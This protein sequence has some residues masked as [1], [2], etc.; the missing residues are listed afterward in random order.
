MQHKNMVVQKRDG[1]F[2][3]YEV[4]K[5]KDCVVRACVGLEVDCIMLESLFD[6]CIFDGIK[7]VDIQKNLIHHAKT[8]C[9]PNSPDWTVVAGR[10]ET[11]NL[12]A[13]TGAYELEFKDFVKKQVSEGIWKHPAFA[14]YTEDDIV[15]IGS[16]LDR[17]RDLNHSY[18][19]VITARNKYLLPGECIQHMF[20]GNAMIIASVENSE[21]R[22]QMIKQTYDDLSNRIISSATPWLGNLRSNGNISSCFIIAPSD[23]IDSI[24]NNLHHAASISKNGGGLGIFIGFLRAR[25]SDLMGRSGRSGGIIGWTKLFNDVALFVNQAGKRAGAFTVALPMWHADIEEFLNCQTEHGDLRQ[26][27]FDIQ[28][29][30]TYS[31]LFMRLKGNSGDGTQNEWHTFCPHEVK[32]VLGFEI[33]NVFGEEFEYIYNKCVKAKID[34]ILKIGKTYKAKE[35]HKL[36]MARQFETGL[37]YI[38]FVDAIN[39]A[40][41]NKHEGNIY[42]TN[43][44]CESF[45]VIVPD[46]YAHTCNLLS[47]TVGRIPV[48]ELEQ[49]AARAVRILDNGIQ[50]TNSPVD[51][52]KAHNLRFRTI[53]VGIQGLHDIIASEFSTYNDLNFIAEVAER[54]CYGAVNE[55]IQLAKERGPYPAFKGSEWENGN[56]V[57]NFKRN[58]VVG[59]DW[60]CVQNNINKFGIR[61]SQLFSPAPNTSSSIFMDAAAGVMP[62]YSAFFYE[63]N[64][65]G[66]IPVAAMHLNKN[67]ISYSRDVTKFKPWVL[68]K[69]IGTLQKFID[70]GISAEY[71]MDKN[72]EDFD[73]LY[74]WNTIEEAWKNKTKAVYYIRTIKKGETISKSTEICV[75]CAG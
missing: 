33:Y 41:P 10:L 13:D 24:M 8:L 49:V 4:K 22:L 3:L 65:N 47:L 38:A 66:A 31:D 73:V 61:N 26:K 6:A 2:E 16:Y 20:I 69:V 45:S 75:G 62:V 44:C 18:G 35:L 27:S 17:T 59:Y 25:G 74:L 23:N 7:T 29:Q 32:K 12:Q 50:L 39:D 15:T 57:K 56:M 34:G 54:I 37:P 40:N 11:M 70:T 9:S 19:S 46:V 48:N 53:G 1:N 71:I 64:D 67:P 42:C 30:V 55:S 58:S 68:P 51:I 5:I 72:N 52:S 28:L 21:N 36:V 14:L 63:D 60:D 43:L